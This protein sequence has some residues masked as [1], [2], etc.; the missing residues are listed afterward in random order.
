MI[1]KLTQTIDAR[2]PDGNQFTI[3]E[4]TQFLKADSLDERSSAGPKSFRLADGGFVNLVGEGRFR[5][6]ATGVV[7][8]AS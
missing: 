1:E 4:F 6:V 2:D 8:I 3:H 7:L 5:V